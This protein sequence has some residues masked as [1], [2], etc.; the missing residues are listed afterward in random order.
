MSRVKLFILAASLLTILA[1]LFVPISM[2]NRYEDILQTGEAYRFKVEPRDPADPFK[3]R[4]VVLTFPIASGNSQD[5]KTPEIISE[6]NRQANAYAIINKD[7][8]GEVELLDIQ[9][10]KPQGQNY[11]AIK[12]RY[13]NSAKYRIQLP[14]DRYYAKESKA[15]RIESL[16]WNRERNAN[17]TFYADIRIKDGYGVIAELYVEDTPIL[18]YLK[19]GTN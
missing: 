19:Q 7:S 18:E 1:Q 16:L 15:P 5:L 2:A 17:R 4:Y 9:N 6:L 13:S 11:I 10:K 14:F 3:G 8:N 12:N